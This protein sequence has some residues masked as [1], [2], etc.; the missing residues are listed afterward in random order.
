MTSLWNLSRRILGSIPSFENRA[1]ESYLKS[2]KPELMKI[3]ILDYITSDGIGDNW[4]KSVE[5]INVEEE[6]VGVRRTHNCYCNQAAPTDFWKEAEVIELDQSEVDRILK[7]SEEKANKEKYER[8]L[9][10]ANKQNEEFMYLPT[11]GTKV[12]I[13]RGRKHKGKKSVVKRYV[14]DHYQTENGNYMKARV[15]S[16]DSAKGRMLLSYINQ[17][18]EEFFNH[19]FSD[20]WNKALMVEGE[21]GEIFFVKPKYAK[22]IEAHPLSEKELHKYAMKGVNFKRNREDRIAFTSV[23]G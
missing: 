20:L 19:F 14:N 18:N 13:I 23:F 22:A 12:E 1:N 16:G 5:F 4:S 3:H 21:D 2:P 7:I 8:R 11:I 9:E 6:Y 10:K 15:G 17:V